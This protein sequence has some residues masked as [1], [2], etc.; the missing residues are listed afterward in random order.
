MLL[1]IPVMEIFMVPRLPYLSR[2]RAVIHLRGLLSENSLGCL[3]T[4]GADT[5]GT[6][7][8]L[9]NER[10]DHRRSHPCQGLALCCAL[11]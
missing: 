4:F 3:R 7:K 9:L 5:V 6:D 1:L 2:R 11:G 8:G 10:M